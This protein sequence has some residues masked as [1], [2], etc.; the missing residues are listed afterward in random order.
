ME[1]FKNMEWRVIPQQNFSAAMNMAVDEAIYES[2]SSSLQN[3]TIR[4]Y[5]WQPGSISLG[6]QQNHEEINFEACVKHD[7]PVVRRMTGG[8]AVFH[9]KNDFT[10]SVIAPIKFFRNNIHAAYREV[11]SWIMNAL[12][13]L[14]IPAQL[15]NRND[16]VVNGKKISGNAARLMKGIYL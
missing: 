15:K 12:R 2:V 13:Q 11:C 7:V 9:D 3:P 14:G 4:F 1:N 10:Y 16:I 5:K 8:A 6:A